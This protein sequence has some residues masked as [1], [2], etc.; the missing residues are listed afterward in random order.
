MLERSYEKQFIVLLAGL[1]FVCTAIAAAFIALSVKDFNDPLKDVALDGQTLSSYL[2]LV[3]GTAVAFAGSWV[4]IRIAQAANAAQ[5]AANQLQEDSLRLQDPDHTQ[6]REFMRERSVLRMNLVTAV[7]RV[8]GAT[9]AWLK[10][11]DMHLKHIAEARGLNDLQGINDKRLSSEEKQAVVSVTNKRVGPLF[12]E[13]ADWIESDVLSKI[14]AVT[15]FLLAHLG[16]E[17][18]RGDKS[19]IRQWLQAQGGVIFALGPLRA[20]NHIEAMGNVAQSCGRLE[21]L[22]GDKDLAEY[23]Y[24]LGL[25]KMLSR[26]AE[27]V[28]E[29]VKEHIDFQGVVDTWGNPAYMKGKVEPGVS[30]VSA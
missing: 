29:A 8:S 1:L 20:C 7:P 17:D 25:V 4:A 28:M 24:V 12:I 5:G 3:L 9:N 21:E 2:A 18:L 26:N 14:N 6:T 27:S 19:R 22:L 15:P 11:A 23:E 10:T 13:I 30:V 16:S